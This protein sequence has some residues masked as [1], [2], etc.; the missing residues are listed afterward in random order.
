MYIVAQQQRQHCWHN[1][2]H[3]TFPKRSIA[4][5]SRKY[6][7]TRSAAV[8]VHSLPRIADFIRDECPIRGLDGTFREQ[9][10]RPGTE[11]QDS[12]V[13]QVGLTGEGVQG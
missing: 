5:S 3:S 9:P 10:A 2:P 1:Q 8:A 7:I 6:S 11:L 4:S 13:V 12:C